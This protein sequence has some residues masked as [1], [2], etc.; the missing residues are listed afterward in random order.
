MRKKGCELT[1]LQEIVRWLYCLELVCDITWIFDEKGP[2]EKTEEEGENIGDAADTTDH[3]R[4]GTQSPEGG[5]EVILWIAIVMSTKEI[6]DLFLSEFLGFYRL[7]DLHVL[8]KHIRGIL[9]NPKGSHKKNNH[10]ICDHDHT[11]PDPPPSFLKT[12]IALGYFFCTV[13]WS[14]G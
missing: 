5:R 11:S 1:W 6:A 9:P 14:F 4:H 10:W 2:E 12:V 8:V 13:F 7:R 3:P